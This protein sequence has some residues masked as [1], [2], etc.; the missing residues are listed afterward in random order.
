MRLAMVDIL[1]EVGQH[2]L[3]YIF[4]E[5]QVIAIVYFSIEYQVS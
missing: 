5:Y 3:G 4:L 2:R 1:F